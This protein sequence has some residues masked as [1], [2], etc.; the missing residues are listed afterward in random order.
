MLFRS[1]M[2]ADMAFEADVEPSLVGTKQNAVNRWQSFP[3]GAR[4]G[5][6][7]HDLLDWLSQNQWPLANLQAPAWSLQA[8]GLLLERK[9]NWLQLKDEERLD[10][11]I[12][13]QEV[14]QTPLPLDTHH[15]GFEISPLVLGQ[16]TPEHMWSEM[17]FNLEAHHVPA[18]LLDQ[19]IHSHLFAGEARPA[20]QPR[21]MQGMLTGSLDLVLQI[22]RAHV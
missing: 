7:I 17:E 8:W 3:A 1:I 2:D 13:L 11:G 4:Y 20:L 10:L 19:H 12:W 5:T 18:K 9:A 6:L 21:L 15:L 22:G 14:I 16:L